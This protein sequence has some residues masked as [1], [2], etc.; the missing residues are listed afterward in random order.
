[1]Y[2]K[3]RIKNS[4][5]YSLK[6]YP[7]YIIFGIILS[8]LDV[9]PNLF[10]NR[11]ILAILASIIATLVL[12]IEIG[13]LAT[14]IGDT[15]HGNDILP[16]FKN[17]KSLIIKG[18]K[19]TIIVIGYLVIP[20]IIA[21]IL[22]LEVIVFDNIVL[23]ILIAIFLILVLIFSVFFIEGAILNFEYHHSRLKSAFDIK[24][25]YHKIKNMGISEFIIALLFLSSASFVVELIFEG[26][27]FDLGILGSI[28]FNFLLMPFLAI[29]SSRFLG[30]IGRHY[31]TEN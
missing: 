6:S 22:I 21:L 31:F 19:E 20:M 18:I 4:L 13:Y 2:L 29:F 1:L 12:F 25:I 24:T 10:G 26:F 17:M 7:N 28:L 3:N 16:K 5:I 15:I 30:L 14:I 8:L 11:N 9:I 27:I 23:G